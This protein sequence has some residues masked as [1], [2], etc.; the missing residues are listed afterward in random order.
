MTRNKRPAPAHSLDQR[1]RIISHS[2]LPGNGLVRPAPAHSLDQR[3]RIISHSAL[4]GNGLVRP[5]PAHSLEAPALL[6]KRLHFGV[7]RLRLD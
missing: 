1:L 6:P 2:A 3:L 4:P 5:A 7:Q